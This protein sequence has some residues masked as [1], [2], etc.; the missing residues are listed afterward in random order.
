MCR[1]FFCH[2]ENIL[3]YYCNNLIYVWNSKNSSLELLTWLYVKNMKWLLDKANHVFFLTFNI[4]SSIFAGMNQVQFK[5][6]KIGS[7]T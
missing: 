4:A 3:K 2:K 6:K 1:G 5:E 7:Q